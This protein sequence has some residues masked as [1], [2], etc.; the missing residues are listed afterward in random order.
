MQ[1][2]IPIMALSLLAACSGNVKQTEKAEA[3]EA[4]IEAAQMA[5]RNAAKDFV[6]R[7]WNDSMELTSHLLDVAAQKNTY[8]MEGRKQEEAAFDSAFI[9]T[10]RTVRPGLA[11]QIEQARSAIQ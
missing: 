11:D 7:E 4:Q 8:I 6:R 3:T 1:K 2:F 5:G 10:L 9:S